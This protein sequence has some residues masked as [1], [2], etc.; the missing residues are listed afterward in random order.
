LDDVGEELTAE[1]E[2]A[3]R[4]LE[5]EIVDEVLVVGIPIDPVQASSTSV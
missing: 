1:G 5:E 2:S 3:D 4:Q